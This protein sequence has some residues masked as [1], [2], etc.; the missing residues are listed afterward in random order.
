MAMLGMLLLFAMTATEAWAAEL[1]GV[2]T[3]QYGS[4]SPQVVHS[5]DWVLRGVPSFCRKPVYFYAT[6][7]PR[8]ISR[9]IAYRPTMPMSMV[10]PVMIITEEEEARL[11]LAP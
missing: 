11:G 9:P 2:P 3:I 6:Q 7:P 10:T 5:R 8:M 4:G 1:G